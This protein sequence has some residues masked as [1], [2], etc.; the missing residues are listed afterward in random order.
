M[1]RICYADK[2]F[3]MAM[4]AIT[5]AAEAVENSLLEQ[6]AISTSTDSPEFAFFTS[7]DATK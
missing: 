3:F 2:R 7:S 4:M 5:T 1:R 6:G